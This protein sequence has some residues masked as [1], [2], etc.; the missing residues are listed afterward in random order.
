M[1]SLEQEKT[2]EILKKCFGLQ[3]GKEF[4][5][6]EELAEEFGWDNPRCAGVI[7][8]LTE[9]G[10]VQ[11]L[12]KEPRKYCLTSAGRG[13]FRVV[14]SGGVFDVIHLGHVSALREAKGLGDFLVA[15]VAKD[16]TV[17]SFKGGKPVLPE[18]QRRTLVESLKP[19]D[20]AILGLEHAG[21]WLIMDTIRPD[22]IAVG[23]DQKN[24]EE[25]VKKLV[26]EKGLRIEV[27]RLSKYGND[28]FDSSTSIKRRVA[29]EWKE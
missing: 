5:T 3:L 6:P 19:V 21:F 22:V 20:K 18:E 24:V 17:K 11:A 2:K 23:Y 15:V 25:N 28:Q 13:K 16:S 4:F 9:K 1:T 14:L 10:F 12:G 8:E 27:V 7:K 29:K 26:R